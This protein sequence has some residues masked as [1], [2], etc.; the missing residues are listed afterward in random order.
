MNEVISQPRVMRCVNTVFKGAWRITLGWAERCCR[1]RV[2]VS[3]A[4]LGWAKRVVVSCGK[5][6]VL[7]WVIEGA[8]KGVQHGRSCMEGAAVRV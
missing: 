5:T 3:W 6:G 4:G 1:I 8:E 2:E 7:N